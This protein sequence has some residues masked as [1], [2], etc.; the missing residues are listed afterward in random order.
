MTPH[1]NVYEIS[2]IKINILLSF[3]YPHREGSYGV[4]GCNLFASYEIDRIHNDTA[5]DDDHPPITVPIFMDKVMIF[6]DACNMID[7]SESHP[8]PNCGDNGWECFAAVSEYDYL[9]V[10]TDVKSPEFGGTRCIVN[11]CDEDNEFTSPPF[12]NFVKRL[13]AYARAREV[14]G[15]DQD[16]ML[17]SLDFLDVLFYER[18]QE[19]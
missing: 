6:G 18:D 2:N 3:L 7:W 12:D 19:Y 13:E 9:F 4:F 17:E 1:V 8:H 16:A 14:F 15:D 5:Q 11:N 10:C